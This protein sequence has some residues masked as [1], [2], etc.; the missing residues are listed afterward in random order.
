PVLVD[1]I[2]HIGP[3][4]REYADRPGDSFIKTAEKCAEVLASL[5]L[6]KAQIGRIGDR[7]S[8]TFWSALDELMPKSTGSPPGGSRTDWV[9]KERS[10]IAL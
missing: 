10:T 8:L 2:W 9:K 6:A 1:E 5:C 7:T 3:I 4:G